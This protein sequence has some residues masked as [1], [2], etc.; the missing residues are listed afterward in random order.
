MNEPRDRPPPSAVP[1]T[2]VRGQAPET[3]WRDDARAGSHHSRLVDELRAPLESHDEGRAAEI[4][5]SVCRAVLRD[6]A[7]ALVLLPAEDRRR[8]QALA[9]Y[10]FTLFDFARQSGVEGERLAAIN[11]W[12][13]TLESA[14]E[15]T[16]PGQPAFV[17]MTASERAR[18]WPREALDE[19][20]QAARQRAIEPRPATAESQ[21][22]ATERLA[23]AL[24]AAVTGEPTAAQAARL[25]GSLLRAYG[26]LVIHDDLRR[27]CAALPREELPDHWSDLPDGAATL[28]LAIDRACGRL[29]AELAGVAG[30]AAHLPAPFFRAA[31]YAGWAARRLVAERRTKSPLG[32]QEFPSI[33]AGRRIALLLRARSTWARRRR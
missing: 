19:L 16:P 13:F 31:L 26:L 9:T 8:V 21:R 5:G 10:A 32:D 29:D 27:G 17:L 14:L 18:P 25:L 1:V 3:D 28:G 33:G 2:R 6:F 11:R 24:A 30:A 7:P 15:G 12:E 4:C 20:H 23:S 22:D